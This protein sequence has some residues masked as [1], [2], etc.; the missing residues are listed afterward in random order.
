MA[1]DLFRFLFPVFASWSAGRGE[2]GVWQSMV[3]SRLRSIWQSREGGK[4]EVSSDLAVFLLCFPNKFRRPLKSGGA[5]SGVQVGVKP[6]RGVARASQMPTTRLAS[7][8]LSVANRG[9]CTGGGG[10][11]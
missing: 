3:R 1:R 2:T 11:C 9:V 8:A 4:D 5:C 7:Q 10:P 6:R